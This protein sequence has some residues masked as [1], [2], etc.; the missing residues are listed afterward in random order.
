MAGQSNACTFTSLSTSSEAM[1]EVSVI[2]GHWLAAF[3]LNFIDM[4]HRDL[5]WASWQ[6]IDVVGRWQEKK[7]N[8]IDVKCLTL[9]L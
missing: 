5:Y 1:T 6:G 3:V 4:I 2:V 9:F 7:T 8:P